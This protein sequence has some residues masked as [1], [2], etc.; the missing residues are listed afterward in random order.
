M[1]KEMAIIVGV[2]E[3]YSA[4]KVLQVALTHDER[5]KVLAFIS[6]LQGGQIR[7]HE[8]ECLGFTLGTYSASGWE[9]LRDLIRQSNE[10]CE[11]DMRDAQAYCEANGIP[12]EPQGEQE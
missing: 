11:R 5:D 3:S 1:I 4:R 8:Q 7:L 12:I 10:Q 9:N 6:A 2:Q